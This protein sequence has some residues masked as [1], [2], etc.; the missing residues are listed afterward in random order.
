VPIPKL[1]KKRR[2]VAPL[3]WVPTELEA[4]QSFERLQSMD[5]VSVI[6]GVLT[7]AEK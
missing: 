3:F 7:L 2:Q 6:V 4:L 5:E 1:I